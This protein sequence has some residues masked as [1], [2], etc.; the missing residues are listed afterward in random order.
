MVD[1]NTQDSTDKFKGA[2]NLN[3]LYWEQFFHL[4]QDQRPDAVRAMIDGDVL[5]TEQSGHYEV[6]INI[7]GINP[8]ARNFEYGQ[9]RTPLYFTKE[10]AAKTLVDFCEDKG[11]STLTEHN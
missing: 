3:N 1:K 5:T 10:D 11:G 4:R 6:K 7:R 8:S 9:D 2:L